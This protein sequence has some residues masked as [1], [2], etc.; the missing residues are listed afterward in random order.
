[1]SLTSKQGFIL[2]LLSICFS[3]TFAQ[4]EIKGRVLDAVTYKPVDAAMVTLHPAGS[5]HILTYT[6]T[7]ADG[8]FTLKRA[9]M[10]DSVTISVQ[11]MTIES[12][13]KTVKSIIEFVEFLVKEN[14][15]ELKE[16]IVKAPKIRQRGDTLDYSVS[17]FINETD[18][19]IGDVLKRLPGIQVLPS[20]QILYQNKEIS[21][22]Y[23][24]DLDLLKGKY[25]LATQNIDAKQVATVQVLENHQ[26]LKVLKNIELPE[27]AAINLKLKESALGAF[28]L[29][30]QVGAGLPDVLLG[31][32]LVGMRFTRTQQNMLVYKGDNTG[33]DIARELISF[34]DFMGNEPMQF[35]SIQAPSPP[36]ISG[37]HYLF[38]D[39]HMF[40]LNDLRKTKKDLTLTGNMNYLMDNQSS[41]SFSKRNIFVEQGETIHISE[42]LNAELAKRELEGSITL[43]GNT[44]N[45]F[46]ENRLHAVSKWN[47][48]I[49]DVV[50]ADNISQLLKQPS[51]Q[52]ENDFSYIRRKKNR[53]FRIGSKLSYL[54]QDHS[55]GVSPI[56]FENFIADN[57]QQDTTIQQ[58]VSFDH[59][60]ANLYLS[61]GKEI[62]RF[63][64]DYT[65]LAFSNLYNMNSGLI[66]GDNSTPLTTDSLQNQIRRNEMGSEL[67]FRMSYKTGSNSRL[68]LD[69]P[70]KYLHL[71]RKDG[72][73]DTN[74]KN[75]YLF[76]NPR[77]GFQSPLTT[78]ISL[79]SSI[80]YSNNIGSIK[81]DYL[82]YIMTTYRSMNWNDGL[83]SKNRNLNAYASLNYKNPFS[84]L[85]ANLNLSYSNL[86]KNML[87]DVRYN[88]ILNNSVSILHPNRSHSFN[89][90]FSLSKSFDAIRSEVK[91]YTGYNLNKA[92][93]MNQGVISDFKSY[94][95]SISPSITTDVGRYIIMQYNA[96]YR[97]NKNEVGDT[98]LKPIHYFTQSFKTSFLPAKKLIFNISFNHYYNSLI[99]SDSRSSWFGNMGVKYKTKRVDWLLDWT[100]VFNTRQF[101]TYSYSEASSYYSEYNLRPSEVLLRIRFKIL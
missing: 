67:K 8:T 61:R 13:S 53:R 20:G 40:S 75:D 5:S 36:E 84:T 38:N 11:A 89:A 88:G 42:D 76:F 85:F 19:S 43:E 12:Q 49:G 100:N 101:V 48:H 64:Y 59:F 70:L 24:E 86:W 18:R 90:G 2:L 82:G 35:L 56:L 4:K 30:A 93:T 92:I 39:A 44:N 51:F 68:S 57:S 71:E 14:V 28:F 60:S 78:R 23:V 46:L 72:V 99:E 98:A 37:Q 65:A 1:M 29:T 7:T 95:F 97:N 10:P 79:I 77:L 15:R 63:L 58:N 54:K 16:V 81:D 74:R 3:Q 27:N 45:Y 9:N 25:G 22:F 69:M 17:S 55:L 91:F 94:A 83:L 47:E 41:S 52:I 87:Y 31:N 6:M 66:L 34:Y 32:E 33:R 80:S 50:S 21:K 73:R 62:K 96:M 26:P